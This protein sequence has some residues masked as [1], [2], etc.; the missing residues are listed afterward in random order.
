MDHTIY[1]VWANLYSNH[2]NILLKQF[3]KQLYISIFL[4]IYVSN[5]LNI[6]LFRKALLARF[7]MVPSKSKPVQV[8]LCQKHSLLHQL[9]LKDLGLLGG[10]LFGE[11][12]FVLSFFLKICVQGV[13]GQSGFFNLALRERNIQVRLYLKVVLKC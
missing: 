12:K 13:R 3:Y 8:I 1:S 4:N 9:T 11:M 7:T 10:V 2:R 5:H 6:T